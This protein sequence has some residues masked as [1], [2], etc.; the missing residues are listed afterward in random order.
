[1]S[2]SFTVEDW[3][4]AL[5]V[6][7]QPLLEEHY[8]E[9]ATDKVR[10]KLAPRWEIYRAA[11]DTD[12]FFPLI[13]RKSGQ[14]VGYHGI[15]VHPHLHYR[16]LVV[17]ESDVLWVRPDLRNGPLTGR[18]LL[19]SAELARQKGAQVFVW[20]TKPVRELEKVLAKRFKAQDHTYL[21]TL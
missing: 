14:L 15:F 1:M 21:Q 3:T 7:L 6:E 4:P 9:L 10:M 13:A 17:A 8:E 11:Y 16:D 2:Y 20:R 5:K 18:L 12:T 19:R